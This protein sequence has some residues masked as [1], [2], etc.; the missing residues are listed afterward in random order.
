MRNIDVTIRAFE[1]D[2][3]PELVEITNRSVEHNQEDQ[4]VTLEVL[5]ER[6]EAPYFYAEANCF[7]AMVDGQ[8]AGYCTAE[9]DPRFGKGWGS[10]YVHPE[11]LR[12]G[13]GTSLLQ[14]AD[15]RHR[16]R[17]RQEMEP[18]MPIKCTRYTRDKNAPTIALLEA[19][20]YEVVR[21]TWI[22]R[23]SLAEPIIPP[24]LPEGIVL[25]PF[26]KERDAQ[27]VYEAEADMFKDNWDSTKIPFNVWCHI[28]LGETL[29]E[30]LCQ[31]AMDSDEIVGLCLGRGWSELEPDLGWLESLGVRAGWRRR[32][33]GSALLRRGFHLLQEHGFAM[34]GL[35]VDSENQDNAVDLYERA[36]MHVY[37]RYL[38]FQKT[39]EIAE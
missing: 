7:V 30:S 31:V 28:R 11:Y 34:A 14:R 13:I 9:L 1:W 18:G 15:A 25:R 24:P 19:E 36:G 35:D 22:M 37:R 26:D 12:R 32:G 38:I 2:D 16:E 17:A 23:I 8:I 20:G 5:R 6:F 21:V 29:D 3:L 27:A 33:L 10:G 39:S 4:F